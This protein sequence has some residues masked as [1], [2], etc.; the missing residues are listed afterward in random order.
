LLVMERTGLSYNMAYQ[1]YA[2]VILGIVLGADASG[3]GDVTIPISSSK[4]IINR[5]IVVQPGA[6]SLTL[7]V[8]TFRTAASG[9]GTSI[10]AIGTAPTSAGAF[11]EIAAPLASRRTETTLYLNKSVGGGIGATADVYIIGTP[12]P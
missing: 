2:S 11:C 10:G 3:T 1:P 6:T 8:A 7:L 4:Y 12:L 5:C 9:G